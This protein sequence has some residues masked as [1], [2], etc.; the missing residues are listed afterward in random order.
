[1]KSIVLLPFQIREGFLKVVTNQHSNYQQ[2]NVYKWTTAGGRP[3][4][5]FS[6][7]RKMDVVLRIH[8]LV[9]FSYDK[10]TSRFPLFLRDSTWLGSKN[11]QR[12]NLSQF[13]KGELMRCHGGSLRRCWLFSNDSWETL[14][15]PELERLVLAHAQI[16]LAIWAKV[17]SYGLMLAE[18]LRVQ[19]F[20]LSVTISSNLLLDWF[21]WALMWAFCT[22]DQS[23]IFFWISG[24]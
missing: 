14:L 24:I 16:R 7:G 5:N 12:K 3:R 15:F 10:Q 6:C 13:Y 23:A 2:Q 9:C 22:K 17:R 8:W 18:S 1:M 20:M 19:S 21:L 4:G 11:Q